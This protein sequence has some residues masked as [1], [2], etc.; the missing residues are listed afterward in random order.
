MAMFVAGITAA[1]VPALDE[2]SVAYMTS[3]AF[4]PIDVFGLIY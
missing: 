2:V 4:S 3:I 1:A